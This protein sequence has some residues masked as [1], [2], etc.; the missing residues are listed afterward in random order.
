M[1]P[2]MTCFQEMISSNNLLNFT[3]TTYTI[4]LI[5]KRGHTLKIH[6]LKHPYRICTMHGRLGNEQIAFSAR[7]QKPSLHVNIITRADLINK[8]K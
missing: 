8:L 5:T 1:T 3:Q 7:L 2:A 4:Y 6:T